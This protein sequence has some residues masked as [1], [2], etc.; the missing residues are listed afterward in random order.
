MQFQGQIEAAYPKLNAPNSIDNIGFDD[1]LLFTR[2]VKNT[3]ENM[4]KF[5][6]PKNSE[7]Y[8]YYQRLNLFR[9]YQSGSTRRKNAMV[10]D[11]KQ[12]FGLSTVEAENLLNSDFASLA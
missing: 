10:G 9:Q 4:M 6:T 2:A 8:S 5:C 7:L 11:L 3:A 12:R 1:F